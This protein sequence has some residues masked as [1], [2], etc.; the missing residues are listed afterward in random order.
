M[1]HEIFPSLTPT[2]TELTNTYHTERT[3]NAQRK[4][5]KIAYDINTRQK[6]SFCVEDFRERGYS[7]GNFRQYVLKLKDM[8]D[9]VL[10]S[11][12]FFY[13]LKGITLS[14]HNKKITDEGMGVGVQSLENMLEHMK[15]T[16]PEL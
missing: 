12:I 9:I 7:D 5:L 15:D 14:T 10:K 16:S 8:I 6:T 2:L 1:E 4:F 11:K 3:T 13:K